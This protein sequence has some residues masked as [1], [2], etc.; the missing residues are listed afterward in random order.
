MA[1]MTLATFKKNIQKMDAEELKAELILLFS[2]LKPV[3][4]FYAQ[5]VL[6]DKEREAILDKYKKKVYGQFYTRTGNPRDVSNAFLRSLIKE[7]EQT[8]AFSYDVADLLLYRVET[9]TEFANQFGGM[10][11]ADYNAAITAFEKF[12]KIVKRD[13]LK[14]HFQDRITTMLRADNLDY[15]YTEELKT[16]A[17][18][19]LDMK[20][21]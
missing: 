1:K 9:A 11:D 4:D 19:Y 16:L 8:A 18:E 15:W 3:Q 13:E 21:A 10:P 5:D 12:L 6:S 14:K 2:K 7:F 17:E 20:R